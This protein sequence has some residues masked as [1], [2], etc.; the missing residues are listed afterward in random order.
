VVFDLSIC[1]YLLF[2]YVNVKN[3]ILAGQDEYGF[4]DECMYVHLYV[5]IDGWKYICMYG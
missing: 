5:C 1:V 3:I 4:M 2:I